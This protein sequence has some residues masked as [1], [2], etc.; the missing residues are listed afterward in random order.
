MCCGSDRPDVNP[1]PLIRN[2]NL[3]APNI[4]EGQY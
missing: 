4:L 3:N 2:T 1:A